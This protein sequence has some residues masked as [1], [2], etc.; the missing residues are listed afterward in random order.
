MRMGRRAG[1]TAFLAMGL[2]VGQ[3]AWA[4]GASEA[5][6]E[7]ATAVAHRGWLSVIPPV[8]AIGLALWKRQVLVA[9]V[10]GL[11]TGIVIIEGN[12]VTAFL[13]LGDEYLVGALA[14]SDHAAI[15]MFTSI[16]GGMVGV[17][18]KSGATEGIVHWLGGKIGGRKGGQTATA[19]MG[20]AIFFDDYANTLLVGATMRPLTD[21]LRISR[22][23]LAWLVDSTAAPVATVAVVSTWVG[24]EVGLIQDAMASLGQSSQ[25][26]TFFLQSIPYSFY[27]LLTLVMVYMVAISGRD[28]GPMLKAER[29]ALHLGQVLA[30]GARP[31][32]DVPV[33]GEVDPDDKP[34]SPLLAGIPI[35]GVIV[36]TALG[37]Y[38]N[39]RATAIAAGVA[40][41]GLREVLNN[42]NSFSVLM[43]ASLVGAT[44]AVGLTTA[45]RRFTL[46]DAMDG[47]IDGAKAMI[48][49]VAI[50]ILAWSL[51]SVCKNLGTAEFLIEV[52]RDVLSARLLP[53]VV[54]VLAAAVSF[55]T[56]T[57]WGTMAIL[58]PLVYPM[59][60][61]LPLDAGLPVATA[62]HI[63][64]AAV[65]AVLAGAVFG[66]HCSPISDT[67]ILSSLATGSDHVDHVKTQLPYALT[68]AG[69]AAFVGYV[70]VGYGVS[71]WISLGVGAAAVIFAVWRF[72]KRAGDLPLEQ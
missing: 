30:P 50:L 21:R 70:P 51:S 10:L 64:L 36:T 19:A 68:V 71:P 9:L 13:R 27:P 63:H 61:Q 8:L 55:A 23:K 43:W 37:L 66:D 26:Y 59:G 32:S 53:L 38:I 3:N 1:T 34:A 69:V 42:A 6:A 60:H 31:A 72:G 62:L 49:A 57:S 35:L 17:L 24:F 41:P 28:Y 58:M 65:S 2:L 46:A 48:V 22:E 20:T 54:F 18:S 25:A 16:L 45:T 33:A 14:D 47:F 40:E 29:R 4:T 56:G 7:A 15:L 11:F 67:T 44:L 12:P 5:A 39:G 52:S